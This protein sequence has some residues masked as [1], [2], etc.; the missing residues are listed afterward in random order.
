MPRKRA[1]RSRSPRKPSLVAALLRP[2]AYDPGVESVRVAETHISWVFLTGEYAYKVKKPVKFPF[3][4]F[5][6]LE[7]RH[8]F[9]EEELRL[10]RRLAPQ[11]YLAVVPIGG[12][13]KAPRVGV[14]PA[15]EYA[16]K[17]REFPEGA[18]LDRLVAAGAV[19]PEALR[20]FG[21]RLARFHAEQPPLS[22][23]Q[24]AASALAAALENFDELRA[25]LPARDQREL[26]ALRNWTEERAA[27]IAP[28][29]ERRAAFGRYRECHGDL[30]LE[31]LLMHDT[32]ILA[33]DA[34]EFDARLRETDVISEASFLTMDLAAHGRADLGYD[35]LTAYLETSG[36]YDGLDVLR[37]YAVHLAL[38][39]TKVR[40]LKAAQKSAPPGRSALAPYLETAR[41]FVARR[42]PLLVITHGLSGSGKTHV[43]Q[44]LIGGLRALRVRSD[45]ERKRMHGLDATARSGSAVGSG[46]YDSGS[47]ARTY[48]RLA[49]VATAAMRNGFDAIVDATFL[50]RT[51]RE[52]LSRIAKQHNARFVILDCVAPEEVLRRRIAARA[53]ESRDASEASLAVLD[54]QLSEQ[55]P[56]G[57]DEQRATIR[58]PTDAPLDVS[59]LLAAFARRSGRRK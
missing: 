8:R 9:C 2:A 54:H 47:T 51:E 12:D 41:D 37:F 59:K 49:D 55:D 29:I 7:R 42:T 46:L 10:N 23:S 11:L 44:A 24:A 34:L 6:T 35:F 1:T 50:R 26:A 33:F 36:D 19:A 14:E 28:T 3:L 17:M 32:Q 56:L 57:A 16:V 38:V 13:D 31:N 18:R 22:P 52:A 20:A 48:A 39:R 15:I 45:L 43:T 53:T 27:S 25:T 21:E 40:A 30:H 5:S 58:V 4:D